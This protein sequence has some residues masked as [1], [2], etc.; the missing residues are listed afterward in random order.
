[1][2]PSTPRRK[3]TQRQKPKQPTI[4]RSSRLS[5]NPPLSFSGESSTSP[6]LLENYARVAKCC[7]SMLIQTDEFG[8]VTISLA[9]RHPASH[10]THPQPEVVT[11]SRQFPR[12]TRSGKKMISYVR[13]CVT[14][15]L[16]MKGVIFS[17][18]T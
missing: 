18:V 7:Q 8:L 6:L 5:K 4:S 11:I 12:K 13:E 9:L 10:V 17:S 16:R 15:L 3:S 1:M 2:K 14:S